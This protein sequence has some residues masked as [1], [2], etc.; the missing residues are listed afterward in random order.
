M[1]IILVSLDIA[2]R[3]SSG[4]AVYAELLAR[5][6][7]EAGHE[8]T[9]VA[10]YRGEAPGPVG[11]HAVHVVWVPQG[12]ANWITFAYRAAL[13]LNELMHSSSADI[14]H[15]LDAHFAYAYRGPY[16]ATLF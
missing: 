6:L 1:R 16:V 2:P 13:L 11:G 4:L 10:S 5:G 7:A 12:I 8:V 9:L 15:F 3:R 14:V